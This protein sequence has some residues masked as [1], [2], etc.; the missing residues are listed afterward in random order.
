ML[1]R[2][3][4]L[5]LL[6]AAT[7]VTAGCL[8]LPDGPGTGGND[9]DNGDDL[10]GT[11]SPP[12]LRFDGERAL[13]HVQDQ[14]RW[15][16]GSVQYRI[17]G[18]PGRAEAADEISTALTDA[19]WQVDRQRW[20]GTYI[21][22]ETNL[23][24]VV[25]TLPGAGNGTL[26][27]GAHYDSRPW[28]D[29][30]DDPDRRDEPVVGANDA[31][32]GVGLLLELARILT[33]GPE[34]NHTVKLL[35]FDAEDGGSP[36]DHTGCDASTMP[37]QGW[38]V[39]STHYASTMSQ[40]AVDATT[41]FL[42]VDMVGGTDLTLYRE[43]YSAR[44]PHRALQDLVWSTA[45]ELGVESFVDDT[46]FSITD[47]HRPFQ[48]RGILAVD[49][50]HLDC[51]ARCDPFPSTHH[52]TTDTLENLSAASL[53]DVGHVVERVVYLLDHH[54]APASAP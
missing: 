41:A 43:G 13:E 10:P 3:R 45:A 30:D 29:K 53:Q 38:I 26:I 15:D 24:N 37:N 51:N 17:P 42:L 23:E 18:T 31:G 48:E 40:T 52:H 7:L 2:S 12:E 46:S 4:L 5:I 6:L 14:V 20:T 49:I 16:N 1:P 32:S 8:G 28:A 39:G 33:D 50:I 25:G 21:C 36:P 9:T 54:G 44:D 11:W 22:Q 47:D 34:L 35:F 27:L 19:G